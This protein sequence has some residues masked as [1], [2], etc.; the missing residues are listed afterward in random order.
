MKKLITLLL[1]AAA[2]SA[3]IIQDVRRALSQNDFPGAAKLLRQARETGGVTPEWLE[4]H[5]W[6]ARG[7]LAAGK[8]EDAARLAQETYDLCI[9]ELKKRPVDGDPNFPIALGAA[10]EVQSQVLG[11]RNQRTEAV[12]Y[13]EGE[14]KKFRETSMRA[15][16]QKNINLLSLEGKPAPA[17][18][19]Q[20]QFG[21]K[22]PPVSQWKGKPVL[23]FFWAHWCGD[24]K[25]QGPILARL[26]NDFASQGLRIIAPTQRY[27]YVAG[28]KE[29]PPDAELKYI[30]EIW[31]QFYPDLQD[32]PV[33]VDEETFRDYGSSTTPTLVLVDRKGI[34][35]LYHPGR[36]P[37]EQLKQ[38]IAERV[39][40]S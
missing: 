39:A 17:V 7:A 19:A 3:G 14:M 20:H 32:I 29:A 24:C 10:I 16:I 22:T 25:Y 15:R 2:L 23:L 12:A 5:S 34:V 9:A 33:P 26:K 4:A 6:T 8:L 38:M 31:K 30:G 27:G 35:R 21:P 28:G 11:R 18:N 40:G 1:C 36:M 13:L 37:Y